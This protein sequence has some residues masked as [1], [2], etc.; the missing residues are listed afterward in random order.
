MM[1]YST[2]VKFKHTAILFIATMIIVANSCKKSAP[3]GSI[4]E[5]VIEY[6]IEYLENNMQKNIPTNLLPKKMTMMFKDNMSKRNIEGFMGLFSLTLITDHEETTTTAFLKVLGKKYYYKGEAKEK[7]FCF[8]EIPGMK[9]DPNNGIGKK[10]TGLKCRKGKV[11]F[12]QEK[13]EPFNFFYTHE[14][15]LKN[16]N[17]GNPYK[18]V[19]GV[20]MNFQVKL[21]KLRMQLS[22]GKFTDNN[23]SDEEFKHPSDHKRVTMKD[24]EEILNTLME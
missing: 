3:K 18:K 9:V 10:I 17:F 12:K 5:G 22:A 8:D 14:I 2:L 6:N 7:T 23:I 21:N 24:M 16:P 4:T 20:L 11:T 1:H 15:R 13:K 19:D